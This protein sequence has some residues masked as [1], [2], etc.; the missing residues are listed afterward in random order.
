L[1]IAHITVL[2]VALTAVK[3]NVKRSI[4][5][6]Q[7]VPIRHSREKYERTCSCPES[8]IIFFTIAIEGDF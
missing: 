7:I 6:S 2:L 8:E 4:A 1:Y 3:N 5:L